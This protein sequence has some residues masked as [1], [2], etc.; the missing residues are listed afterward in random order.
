MILHRL[1]RNTRLS[2]HLPFFIFVA[3]VLFSLT[4]VAHADYVS[5]LERCVAAH[6]HRA[7][8]RL[9]LTLTVAKGVDNPL[10]A[11]ASAVL[12][13]DCLVA[14][15]EMDAAEAVCGDALAN[16]A[17]PRAYRGELFSDTQLTGPGRG[18]RSK[19]GDS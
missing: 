1:S 5:D 10:L 8:E 17:F 13:A 15:G 3:L 18:K 2:R 4:A 7:A 19:G 12:V 11:E 14:R 6:E 9:E 16:E